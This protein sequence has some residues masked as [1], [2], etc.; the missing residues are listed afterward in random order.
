MPTPRQEAPVADLLYVMA[1]VAFFALMVLF[2][3]LCERI[4]GKDD[5][6]GTDL[7]AP[8]AGDPVITAPEEVPA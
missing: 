1:I 8:D 2:V 5:V 6:V 4:V 7:D 3:R